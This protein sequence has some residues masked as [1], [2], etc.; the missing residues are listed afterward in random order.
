MRQNSSRLRF[1]GS[2]L[3][4]EEIA[5]FHYLER[6]VAGFRLTATDHP[7]GF[8]IP[9]H[10]HTHPYF[11]LVLRGCLIERCRNK[12]HECTPA[13]FVF[14]PSGEAHSNSFQNGGARC[15]WVELPLQFTDSIFSGSF[16]AL[17]R[18]AYVKGGTVSWL[19]TRAY[20][21]ACHW[22][23]VSPLI[24]EGIMVEIL[25]H[26]SR[27]LRPTDRTRPKWIDETRDMLHARF[28]E[29]LTL[30]DL[31][32]AVDVHP[33]HLATVF[34]QRYGSSVGDYIRRLRVEFACQK[35]ATTD[36]PLVEIALAAGFYDQS[37]FSK[38]FKMLVG[39]TPVQYRENT[40]LKRVQRPCVSTRI[41]KDFMSS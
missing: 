5:Q 30:Y 14:T 9:K 24:I 39:M 11:N 3:T 27:T 18:S 10:S 4:A 8:R 12:T 1:Y 6:E 17:N 21:E 32:S 7:A 35:I 13:T 37:H 23:D 40:Q 41:K 15:F 38:V 2:A 36:T 26:L 20:K 34:R 25:A 16:P 19:A 28:S 22:D 29:K 33:V 31:S